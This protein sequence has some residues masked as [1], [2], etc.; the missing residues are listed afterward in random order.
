YQPA[1][2]GDRRVVAAGASRETSASKSAPLIEIR[3]GRGTPSSERPACVVL[4]RGRY[5]QWIL[6]NSGRTS[7]ERRKR[8][9]HSG[10]R[11]RAKFESGNGQRRA[12]NWPAGDC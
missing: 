9:S 2:R 7:N 6:A 4:E 8:D 11:S 5:R 12:A 3:N 10:R 1:N